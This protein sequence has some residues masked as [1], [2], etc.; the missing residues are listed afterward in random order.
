M[1]NFNKTGWTEVYNDGKIVIAEGPR[2]IG[3]LQFDLVFPDVA[4]MY[5]LQGWDGSSLNAQD[6]NTVTWTA[7]RGY[8]FGSPSNWD[9]GR[10]DPSAVP[11]PGALLLGSMGVGLVG[12][13]RRRR[14]L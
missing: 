14:S 5:L 1:I 10:L 3:Q 13:L 2:V 8:S 4:G 9:V 12:W 6:D 11:A 7:Q